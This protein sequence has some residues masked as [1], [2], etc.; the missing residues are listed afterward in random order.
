MEGATD[1]NPSTLNQ[2]AGLLVLPFLVVV[3]KEVASAECLKYSHL[4]VGVVVVVVQY[5]PTTRQKIRRQVAP[6]ESRGSEQLLA[7]VP[8]TRRA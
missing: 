5:Y 3:V 1:P 6:V 2:G 7:A 4:R 8:S